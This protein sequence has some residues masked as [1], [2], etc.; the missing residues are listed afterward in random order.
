MELYPKEESINILPKDGVV[1]YFPSF[2]DEK[3]CENYLEKLIKEIEWENEV[4]YLFGKE[5]TMNRKIAFYADDTITYT[6]SKKEKITKNWNEI[7]FSIKEKIEAKTKTKYN[8]CLLNLYFDGTDGMGWHSDDENEII[9]NSSIASISFGA[10][11]KFSFKHKKTKQT[12]SLILENGSLLE[13]KEDTQ[14]N[15]LHALPKTKKIKN[16]RINLTFRQMKIKN[17]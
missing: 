11:R 10:D 15:W 6:Y 12:H 5:I 9:Q 14:K 1:L 17:K 7:L 3:E 8:A 16:I 2:Y 4:I 13:M